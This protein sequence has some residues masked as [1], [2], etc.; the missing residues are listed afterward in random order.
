MKKLINK[1]IALLLVMMISVTCIFTVPVSALTD[2][3]L[4]VFNKFRIEEGKTVMPVYI[5]AS[6]VVSATLTDANNNVID[7]FTTLR[8]D[9]GNTIS[10]KKAFS[11]MQAGTYYLNV[12]FYL[13]DK[14]ISRSLGITC[15]GPAPKLTYTNTYQTYTDSGDVKQ[16]F[17]FSYSNGSG[18][19]MNFQIYDQYGNFISENVVTT[20]YVNG[21]YGFDWDYYPKNGGLMVT[22]GTYILK[23]WAEGQTPKQ[24][25]FEVTLSEG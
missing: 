15:K 14:P 11:T 8:V 25:N 21:T 17:K 5:G 12:K 7:T 4:I 1:I 18:K 3:Q 19:K 20:K 22:S 6:G 16:V 23:Y 10:Y 24:Q 13:S 2:D 9:V